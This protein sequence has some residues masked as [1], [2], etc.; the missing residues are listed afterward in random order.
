M[1]HRRR[2]SML[3]MIKNA[4]KHSF[5]FYQFQKPVWCTDRVLAFEGCEYGLGSTLLTLRK[6]M[7][8]LVWIETCW[9]VRYNFHNFFGFWR[10]FGELWCKWF[11]GP[12]SMAL[13]ALYR[14]IIWANIY[15]KRSRPWSHNKVIIK[16]FEN[17]PTWDFPGLSYACTISERNQG[18]EVMV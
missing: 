3:V 8:A 2:S 10:I 13:L 14:G 1:M 15:G 17:L 16:Q 7:Q 9:N 18:H 5:D 11:R 4:R 6:W 12:F